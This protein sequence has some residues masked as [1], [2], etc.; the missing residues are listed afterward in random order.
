MGRQTYSCTE[1]QIK[2]TLHTLL[3]DRLG[4]TLGVTPFKLPG[5]QVAQPTLQQG[6]DASHEEH[7]HTPAWGPDPTAGAFAYW[8]LSTT[9]CMEKSVFE[10]RPM[11]L[12][13]KT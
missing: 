6:G 5:Q 2:V 9:S 12:L 8:S 10:G 13:K 1:L 11:R 4:H 7:P 3:G